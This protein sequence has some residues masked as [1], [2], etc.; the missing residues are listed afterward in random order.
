MTLPTQETSILVRAYERSDWSSLC[1][2]HDRTRM[3][4]LELTVGVAAFLSL[5]ETY[6]DEGL[7]DGCLMVAKI[8][9][10]VVG[11][12]AFDS[13]EVTWLYVDP[14]HYRNGIGRT[15]LQNAIACASGNPMIELLDGNIPAQNLYRSEGFEIVEYRDGRLVGNEAFAARGLVLNLKQ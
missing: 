3:D 11:F 12:V 1:D 7:F 15:L 6:E 14:D 4:E 5:A 10:S 13:D 8:E 9:E 2:I